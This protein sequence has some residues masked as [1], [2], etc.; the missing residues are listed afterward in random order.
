MNLAAIPIQNGKNELLA[1]ILKEKKI[2]K[3]KDE[4]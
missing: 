4:Q 2:G 3:R 1:E